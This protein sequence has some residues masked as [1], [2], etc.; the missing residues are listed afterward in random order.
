MQIIIN[1]TEIVQTVIH[2]GTQTRVVQSAKIKTT[3]QK[4]G[5]PEISSRKMRWQKKP[6][7]KS[8]LPCSHVGSQTLTT[9]ESI[10][11]EKQRLFINILKSLK[12]DLSTEE[13]EI[14]S[15]N[16]SQKKFNVT[17]KC[18]CCVCGKDNI[19][20]RGFDK[21]CN[22]TFLKD[23]KTNVPKI[24]QNT[25]DERTL[26][27]RTLKSNITGKQ[28]I[29]NLCASTKV[30]KAIKEICD[31][32]M[33]TCLTSIGKSKKNVYKSEK[34][35]Q[36]CLAKMSAKSSKIHNKCFQKKDEERI[37]EIAYRDKLIKCDVEKHEDAKDQKDLGNSSNCICTKVEKTQS[38]RLLKQEI[39]GCEEL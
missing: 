3:D 38:G 5:D 27:N 14:R 9:H 16:Y 2:R 36:S 29:C 10:A 24:D 34:K 28:R 18:S 6:K 25:Q 15:I 4:S 33:C 23:L 35:D 11:S 39:C 22:R 32:E 21:H 20:F 17:D 13:K 31:R 7:N 30:S 26:K 1:K 37:D 8:A 12:L 19:A